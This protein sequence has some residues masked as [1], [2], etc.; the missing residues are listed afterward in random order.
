MVL[1][2]LPVALLGLVLSVLPASALSAGEAQKVVELVEKLEP[3]HGKIA[4]DEEEADQWFEDDSAG[5][6]EKAGFSRQ[7]WKEAFDALM[8]GYLALVPQ[9][10]VDAKLAEIKTRIESAADISAEQ[11]AA[12]QALF[13]E[14]VAAIRTYRENGQKHMDVVRPLAARLKPL[15]MPDSE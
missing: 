14:Q 10:E 7:S 1:R 8:Q 9:S 12:V 2:I 4:Y 11:K 3:D 15:V 5:L 6:I 13:D